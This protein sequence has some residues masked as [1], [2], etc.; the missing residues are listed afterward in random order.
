MDMFCSILSKF[1]LLNHGDLGSLMGSRTTEEVI[2]TQ[3]TGDCERCGQ[4]TD[5][6][7]NNIACDI[8]LLSNQSSSVYDCFGG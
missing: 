4:A 2:E 7:T 8:C 6:A 3:V 5:T 1:I